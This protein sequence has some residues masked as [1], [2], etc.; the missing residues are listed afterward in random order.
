MMEYQ[1]PCSTQLYVNLDT[2]IFSVY[3]LTDSLDT[4]VPELERIP[5]MSDAL[6]S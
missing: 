5:P 3:R 2:I 1:F 6:H 4:I